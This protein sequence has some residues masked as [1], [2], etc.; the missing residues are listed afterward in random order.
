MNYDAIV[1]GGG[2]SGSTIAL[3]LAQAGWSV[4]IVEK[5]IFPRRKVCGE[6]ISA[7]SLPLLH[8]LGVADFYINH[9]GPEI[10]RVGL[11]AGE[12]ILISNMPSVN[13]LSEKWG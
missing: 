12:T 13:S 8:R 4:A 5:K 10:Q 6:F 1:I 2:P 3:L 11:F 7:T 9:A